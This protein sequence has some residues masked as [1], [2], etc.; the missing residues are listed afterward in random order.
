MFF[1]LILV[2]HILFRFYEIEERNQFTWDQVDNAWAAKTIIVDQKYPLIGMQ[3]KLNSGIYIGPFYYY[4][5][6][7]F[8]LIT[9]LDPI[10]S[11]YIALV[12]SVIT[13]SVLF[14]V[15]RKLFSDIPA[16]I[17][18]F[19]YS[20]GLIFIEADRVQWPVN[21]IPVIS[22]LIFYSLY[23]VLRGKT[24]HLIYLGVWLGL[25]FHIHFTSIFYPFLILLSLP[26][27]PRKKEMIKHAVMGLGI[28]VVL[29]SPI[30]YYLLSTEG[31]A[32][33]SSYLESRFHGL[34]ARR[35]MQLAS[36]AFI[37]FGHY[38]PF[39]TFSFV[40][41][42]FLPLFAVTFLWKNFT[43]TRVL[44]VYLLSLWF[45]LPWV[46]LSTYSGKLTAYYFMLPRLLTVMILGYV[47]YRI[48]KWGSLGKAISLTVVLLF[49]LY[50]TT[51]FFESEYQGLSYHRTKTLERIKNGDVI[52]FHQGAPDS[53]LYYFY[54]RE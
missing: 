13:A 24:V 18:L 30:L 43:K 32:A 8:Y 27:F 6:A 31:T 29:I 17:S 7:P 49:G 40:R 1:V 5:V 39:S 33:G 38:I 45:V 28:F 11:G 10:A 52:E 22:L 16:L 50:N 47:L 54:T 36:D 14:V 3:A 23:S 15:V 42:I 4:F 53:Y 9:G 37:E 21:F 12:S 19:I 35:V 2:L 46:A 26:F 25:S 41:F 51:L 20:V 34:H 48:F 44:F